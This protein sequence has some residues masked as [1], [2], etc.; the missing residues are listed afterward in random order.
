MADED[1]VVQLIERV[2]SA[3]EELAVRGLR[4]AGA[5]QISTLSILRD[6]LLRVNAE[7]LAGRLDTLV[8]ALRSD[9]PGAAGALLGLR[10]S[11]RLF[12][13]MLTREVVASVL[14]GVAG[15]PEEDSR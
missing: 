10:A 8:T 14:K 15:G 1:E 6:E 11:L 13:R 5:S 3:T 4:A 9:D 2:D 12:E 7:H